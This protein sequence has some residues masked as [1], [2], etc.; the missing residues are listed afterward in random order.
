M[1]RFIPMIENGSLNNMYQRSNIE[2]KPIILCDF[3]GTISLQDVT[4]LLLEYFGNEGCEH[5]EEQWE[6]GIIG[7]KECMSKQIALMNASREELDNVLAGVKI[8]ISFKSFVEEALAKK[9]N[10]NIV[11][12]GLDY[13]IYTIL[14]NNKL[15]FLPIY[16]N[17]LLHDQQR[18]WQLRFPYA[19]D[20]C[21]KA[22][23]NCKC[24]HLQL[25]RNLFDTVFYVGD[26]T[27][28]FCV[29][30]NVDFVFAKDKLINYCEKNVISHYPISHFAD[31][32]PFLEHN[33]SI[34]S[35]NQ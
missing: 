6:A 18:N 9:F 3:D 13:A 11:S 15:D 21:I 23:G 17:Q 30:N 35:S 14:K 32:M 33:L 19:N 34:I 16:A 12:D 1:N 20:K 5:L 31:I 25:Q 28:D 24:R 22:S 2:K 27:S 4:D 8:D 29:S 26:G 7:S 10:I